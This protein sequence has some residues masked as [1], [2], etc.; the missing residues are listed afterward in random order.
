MSLL[1][2]A[3]VQSTRRWLDESLFPDA[4]PPPRITPRRAL[5]C[6]ALAVAGVAIQLARMW[7]SVPLNTIWA[8]DGYVWLADARDR[9]FF[10]VLT[11]P[12]NGYVEA[13]LRLV[14]EPVALLPVE[15]Y[16]AAMALCG[17]AI[18]TGC[19]FVVWRASAGH[20]ES[21][22]LRATLAALVV[23]LPIVGVETL[24]NLTNSIWFLLFAS[25]WVLLWRPASFRRALLAGGVVF[26]SAISNAGVVLF[27]PLW[28]AR[29]IAVRDRRDGAIVGGFALGLALQLGLSA[30][31]TNLL[32]ERGRPQV[33]LTPH[34]DWGLI[35][36][37]V[38][39]V[40]GGALS[41]QEITG[42]L[43]EQLG[44]PL[45]IVL[46]AAL[47]A[48]VASAIAGNSPRTRVLIPLTVAISLATFLVSGYRRWDAGGFTLLWP[49]G[50]SNADSAHYVVVPTLLLLSALFVQ[51]DARPRS[52][53]ST[54]WD[55]VRAGVVSFI[56]LAA[57]ASFNVGDSALRGTPTWS[58]AL[59]DAR[60][61][62]TE[63]HPETALV[64]VAPPTFEYGI[65]IPCG[66]LNGSSGSGRHLWA[67]VGPSADRHRR[68][69]LDLQS[70][71]QTSVIGRYLEHGG[72]ARARISGVEHV[73]AAEAAHE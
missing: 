51:L 42:Y 49:H 59:D 43:W 48:F 53:S 56:V 67:R 60:A 47:V 27:A 41:G 23:L 64:R 62:C 61:T 22:Y 37:Y 72:R 32:S 19:A 35:P 38:Q 29:A 36:A 70:P 25:F 20:I 69:G 28:L 11:L 39:R 2:S 52:V 63:E 30:G 31:Q 58:E 16:A 44:T 8:E 10:D 68:R 15:W 24:D 17:A 34:W 33:A 5:V 40:I 71:R 1:D 65:S 55:S 7:P 21:N 50:I 14:A 6:A 26:L 12:Y 45:E 57:L 13:L 4:P 66:D 3:R 46:A 73:G 54:A 18:V 9:G